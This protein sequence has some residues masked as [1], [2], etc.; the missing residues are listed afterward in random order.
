M[1]KNLLKI[2]LVLNWLAFLSIFIQVFLAG[3]ALFQDYSF[4]EIHKS[5]ALFK[6]LYFVMFIVGLIGKLPRNLTWLSIAIF[7]VANV[8]YY[9]AHGFLASLHVVIPFLI[10][11]INLVI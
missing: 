6:Y 5:F 4:W 8:Q 1:R 2:Y 11:W 10:F 7:A 3:V 9:T